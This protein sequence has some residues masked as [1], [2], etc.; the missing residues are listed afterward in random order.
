MHIWL[1]EWV[2]T[3]QFQYTHITA[4]KK[5]SYK[6][7]MGKLLQK[8]GTFYH[9]HYEQTQVRKTHIAGV[10]TLT[11]FLHLTHHIHKLSVSLT[12]CWS[13]AHDRHAPKYKFLLHWI[14]IFPLH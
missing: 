11:Y 8:G 14:G 7:C 2:Y 4:A 5:F 13:H 1:H 12:H 9:R 6:F 3:P 10:K